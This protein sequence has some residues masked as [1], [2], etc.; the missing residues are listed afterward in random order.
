V[1]EEDLLELFGRSRIA[2][3]LE[4][5]FRRDVSVAKPPHPLCADI[6]LYDGPGPTVNRACT[7]E[8]AYM[9]IGPIEPLELPTGYA[10]ID[11][12]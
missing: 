1:V 10:T 7:G 6:V 3:Q 12:Y 8:T 4:S 5:R 2:P 11:T 9:S